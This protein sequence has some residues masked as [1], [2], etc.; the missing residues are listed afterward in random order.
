MLEEFIKKY[1][2][3][4]IERIPISDIGIDVETAKVL[5]DLGLLQLTSNTYLEL[6]KPS[7]VA[8]SLCFL[9]K[10]DPLF[11]VIV[12]YEDVK[13]LICRSF[14]EVGLN[15][16]FIGPPASGKTLFLESIY[17]LNKDR[18]V[19][20]DISNTTPAGLLD[21]L[22]IS[23]PEILCLDE[24]DKPYDRRVYYT[25]S[26]I[27]EYG[28]II[29]TKYNKTMSFRFRGNVYGGA[30]TENSIQE[31]IRDRF[32]KIYLRTYTIDEIRE[33]TTTAL[34][35]FGVIPDAG[36]AAEVVDRCINAGIISIRDIIKIGKF[37]KSKEDINLLNKIIYRLNK[38]RLV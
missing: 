2:L 11:P 23:M 8:R 37:V 27:L 32:L 19:Y 30:N 33:I 9:K 12:G 5:N 36:L 18:A 20:V 26:N 31:H 3:F 22:Y 6:K 29:I 21:L 1:L 14:N 13:E 28:N 16:L 17:M 38:R 24:L 7:A 10:Y 34:V 15:I 4:G 25:L 35:K